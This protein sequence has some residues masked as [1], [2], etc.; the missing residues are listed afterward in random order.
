[1]SQVIPYNST[2]FIELIGFFVGP[3]GFETLSDP[4]N[5]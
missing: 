1:M 4:E 5:D 2:N 3:H